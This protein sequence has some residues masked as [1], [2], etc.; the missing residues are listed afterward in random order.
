MNVGVK[1]GVKGGVKCG[2]KVGE[3]EGG[4]KGS[5]GACGKGDWREGGGRPVALFFPAFMTPSLP[6]S[7]TH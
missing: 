6:H 4:N 3:M 7:I 2:L 1:F 5:Y